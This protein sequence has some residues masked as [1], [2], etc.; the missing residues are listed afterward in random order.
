MTQRALMLS[1][2]VAIPA[3]LVHAHGRVAYSVWLD[4]VE[5]CSAAIAPKNYDAP[6][7]AHGSM[8]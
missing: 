1:Q 4:L 7:F 8:S 6:G 2:S 5:R 3:L